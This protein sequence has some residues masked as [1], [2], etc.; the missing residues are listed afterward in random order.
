M[1]TQ[2]EFFFCD[3]RVGSILRRRLD[4]MTNYLQRQK[5]KDGDIN[6]CDFMRIN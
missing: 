5:Y 2:V 6:V 4:Y 3:A 1:I